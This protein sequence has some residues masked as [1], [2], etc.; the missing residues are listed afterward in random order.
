[1][2]CQKSLR[3][4]C[5]PALRDITNISV[6][7][8]VN[9]TKIRSPK[10]ETSAVAALLPAKCQNDVETSRLAG[11]SMQTCNLVGGWPGANAKQLST[12]TAGWFAASDKE[13]AHT[14]MQEDKVNRIVE[15]VQL[16][17]YEHKHVLWERVDKTK[18]IGFTKGGG[19]HWL[20]YY[21][22]ANQPGGILWDSGFEGDPNEIGV[23]NEVG[24]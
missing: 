18:P 6:K 14:W 22:E 23:P 3:R 11:C 12:I 7:R 15:G 10:L 16:A 13:K 5:L 20:D 2:V 17:P 4:N 19:T 24:W 21:P 8:G 9:K 1:M